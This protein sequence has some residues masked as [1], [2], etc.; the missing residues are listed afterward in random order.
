[1]NP[2]QE[3]PW[4]SIVTVV[5]DDPR[6]LTATAAS[7]RSQDLAGVEWVVIDSSADP[8]T[9]RAIVSESGLLNAR[10]TWTSPAGI[11]PAMNDGLADARGTYVYFANAGDTLRGD[12]ALSTVA[13]AVRDHSPEWL[14]APVEIIQLDGSAVI[15][16]P[17]DYGTEKRHLFSRGL[18]PP[19]QGT[20]A[21][22]ELL[23]AVGG[24]DTTYRI[25][26]DY[27]AFLR[28]S[29]ASDPLQLAYVLATFREGG[30]STQRWQESFAEFHR[31]RLSILRP[32]GVQRAR[33]QASTWWHFT[34]V[35]AYRE[36]FHRPGRSA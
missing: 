18:F 19:H 33:E 34:K 1:M 21:K 6:G 30:A 13:D 24:F 23:R 5:K 20:V 8:E 35:F 2:A 17:W 9:V 12:R 22:V 7:I 11:Y 16:P 31:A 14:F 3:S 36:V 10:T 25:A 15:T 4:L 29:Q 26:A 28:L 27:A 32:A